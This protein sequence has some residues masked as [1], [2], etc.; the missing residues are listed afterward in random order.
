MQSLEAAKLEALKELAY[1][2]G[3]EINNPLANISARAQALLA[4]ERHPH[5]RRMLASIH[6]QA[7]R[8]HE[9][10]A[11][12]M[13]FARPPA[14]KREPVNLVELARQ[15]RAELLEDA[16][17]QQTELTLRAP[18]EPV[19]ILADW[20]QIAATLRSLC[21][22]SLEALVHGGRLEIALEKP[23]PA[24]SHVRVSVSD[25]GPG[26]PPDARP[27]VFDP[28]YSGREAGRG[29]GLGLSKCWRIVTMHGGSIG[30][31]SSNSQGAVFN[32]LL[33]RGNSAH[34]PPH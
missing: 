24:D 18:D 14:P 27:H 12:M 29:L 6:A 33:P 25:T 17:E 30:V 32:V 4:D 22:N 34:F 7:M 16:R 19:E 8:A 11:D 5:R 21:V 1:G 26:I 20:T 15:V 13:L 3:H 23:A 10:I 31:E 28:F 9:M 2:A